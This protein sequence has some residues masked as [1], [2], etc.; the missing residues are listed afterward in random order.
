MELRRDMSWHLLVANMAG[1]LLVLAGI[2]LAALNASSLIAYQDAS[3]RHGGEVIELGLDALPQAG[4]H[5][6][7]A[8]VVGT[9]R[10][11]EAP[12][13][14]EF[15]QSA[16]TPVLVRR[17]EMFQW[18]EINIGGNA[19]YELDW[20]DHPVDSGRFRNPRGHANPGGFPIGGKQ[21]DAGLVQ[22]G[23]FTLSPALIHALPGSSAVTP[24][25]TALPDN[26]AASFSR[27]GDYL[28]TSAQPDNPRLGDLRVSWDGVPLQQ[29][30]IVARLDGA[31]LGAASDTGDGK[32]YQVQV[33]N[34]PLLDLF[35]DLPV[36]PRFFMVWRIV[37]ILL[38]SL[39]ALV[40]LWTQRRRQKPLL[41]LGL[42]A[43]SVGS[44]ASIL[45]FGGQD[46][47]VLVG[48]VVVTLVGIA[49][50]IWCLRRRSGSADRH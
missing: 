46:A 47:V 2:A 33:G 29:V 39:G 32:G 12:H 50:S 10:V 8:R 31:R 1:A 49:L 17:V 21:F 6:H 4:Q 36:P 20:V 34:V 27:H 15:N 3:G 30:T 19:H 5:G 38:A 18:R 41:A 35:P 44:V 23:G 9:P 28:V 45:W 7:M 43:A 11:V 25:V 40:L 14:P 48:W 24:D 42:G 16:D 37:A 26:L 22:I 13:D